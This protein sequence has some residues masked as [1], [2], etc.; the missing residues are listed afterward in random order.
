MNSRFETPRLLLRRYA[1]ARAGQGRRCFGAGQLEGGDAGAHADDAL[2]VGAN[3]RF[4]I[5][6][7]NLS[8]CFKQGGS[9][10]SRGGSSETLRAAAIEKGW[11][12]R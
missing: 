7:R 6:V 3:P 9:L 1:M 11:P 10:L 4:A 8:F 2:I 5:R 12:R